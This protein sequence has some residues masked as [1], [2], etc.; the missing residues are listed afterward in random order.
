MCAHR[1]PFLEC[2][3]EGIFRKAI[4]D[5]H[6]PTLNKRWPEAL[7]AVLTDCWRG[8]IASRPEFAQLLPRL[9]ALC[10]EL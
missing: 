8:D 2:G 4:L 6:R 9:D 1:P 7:K 10:T 3:S 5:G